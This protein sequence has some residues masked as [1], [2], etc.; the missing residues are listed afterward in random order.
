M[1]IDNRAMEIADAAVA[2]HAPSRDDVLYLL[3]FHHHSPEAAYVAVRAREIAIAAGGSTGLV[4]AQIGV[5]AWPCPENCRFCS[6]AAS[7][8]QAAK[9]CDINDTFEV[10]IE[11]IVEAAQH[12]DEA[13]VSLISLMAT[14]GL[15]FERYLEMVRAVRA[16]VSPGMPLM[17][18][19]GDLSLD[20]ARALKEAGMQ[21]AYHARRV[22][23]GQLTD[24]DP[25][26]RYET[27]RNIHD[28]GLALMTGVEPLY[29]AIDA[30]ELA[31]RI[32]EIPGF[33]PYCTGA[34][35]LSSAK[36]TEMEDEVP[37][38]QGKARLVGAIIRLVCGTRVPFGGTGGAIWVDAGTDPRGRGYGHGREWVLSQVHKTKRSLRQDEWTVAEH[39]TLEFF[40]KWS[41]R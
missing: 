15:P 7:N 3:T 37:S 23:E 33:D 17:A 10:P 2:G 11:H 1:P 13:G 28:A 38:P 36:G 29:E 27:I 31:D 12:F 21:A 14:A 30:D 4:H 16:A 8:A 41:A 24:I 39:P 35:V 22:Y 9:G 20:Q 40:E 18:N 6:F 32:M 25:A 26:A 5:D 19:V 34:C